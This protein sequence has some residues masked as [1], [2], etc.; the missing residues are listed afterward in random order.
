M[1]S[2]CRLLLNTGTKQKVLLVAAAWRAGGR[3][4]SALQLLSLPQGLCSFFQSNCVP[5]PP[6]GDGEYSAW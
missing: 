1:S 6:D 5:I 2:A 3:Q 4:S